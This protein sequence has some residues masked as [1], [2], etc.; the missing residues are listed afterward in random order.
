MGIS[1][2]WGLVIAA[3][4]LYGAATGR[5][6]E[7]GSAAMEGAGSAV[8]LIVGMLGATS[9]WCGL[10]EVMREAGVL[11]GLTR[12]LRPVLGRLFPSAGED[13]E[14]RE[15]LSANI[16]ANLLGVGNAATPAG[17]RAVTLM[18]R[19]GG[20]ATDEMC[21]LIVMNT[22]SIQLIP[23][24]VAA[25]RAAN[26]SGEPFAILPAVWPTSAVSVTAG[27]AAAEIMRRLWR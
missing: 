11:S 26:G 7:V 25:V 20:E 2:I 6:G 19:G 17:I 18:D 9:L 24:T 8:T 27:L 22:A 23:A 4:V 21:R 1:W 3:S 12:L 13:P 15:A 14:T 10:M 5:I 16:A